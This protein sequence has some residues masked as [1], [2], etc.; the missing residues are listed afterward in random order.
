ME[1][2]AMTAV[3]AYLRRVGPALAEAANASQELALALDRLSRSTTSKEAE[4]SPAIPQPR[5]PRQQDIVDVLTNSDADGGLKTGEIAHQ[6]GM[7]QP[8]AYTTLQA[9][10]KQNIVELVPGVQPQ[11][12]RL[13]AKYRLSRQIIDTANLLEP[14]EW[15][16]YGEIGFVVYGHWQAGLAVARVVSRSTE[17]K[18]PHRVLEHTGHI[19]DGWIGDGGGPEECRRRLVAEGVEVSDDMFAH[20]RHFVGH[21]RLVERLRNRAG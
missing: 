19:A 13:V 16:G 20:M 15:T 12:W 10:Q 9:L 17:V 11:R 3:A 8:N 18:Y 21:E 6:V 7:D 1:S 2:E 4:A 5:G 14:G